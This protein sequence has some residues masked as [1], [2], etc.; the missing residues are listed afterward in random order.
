MART[1]VNPEEVGE[2]S[3]EQ[4]SLS[5][6]RSI[7][8]S[9]VFGGQFLLIVVSLVLFVCFC[10]SVRRCVGGG[11]LC[12]FW[13][14][15]GFALQCPNSFHVRVSVRSVLCPHRQEALCL[16]Y[17]VAVVGRFCTV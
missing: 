15:E 6:A 13:R 1:G 16:Y 10:S 4:L 5:S 11:M 14:R 7:A 2:V 3:L 12:C 8:T 9:M 17:I